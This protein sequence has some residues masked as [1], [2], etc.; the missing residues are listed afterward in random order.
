MDAAVEHDPQGCRFHT[1]VDGHRAEVDYRLADGIM[2]ITHT[3]VPEAIGGRGIAASL[4]RAA[5]DTARARGWRVEA[6]CAY[7]KD[8]LQRHKEYADLV[9]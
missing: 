3:G 8:Y 4:T 1:E 7:A 2:T 5:L 9:A 6:H